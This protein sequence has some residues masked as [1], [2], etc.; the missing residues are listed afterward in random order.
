MALLSLSAQ[1]QRDKPDPSIKPGSFTVIGSVGFPKLS[2]V[3]REHEKSLKAMLLGGVD[4]QVTREFI[5]GFQYAN[6][7]SSH[8]LISVKSN[9]FAKNYIQQEASA[10]WHTLMLTAEIC[11]LNRGRW[12]LSGGIGLGM[13]YHSHYTHTIDSLGIS[14]EDNHKDREW[15]GRI[16]VINAKFRITNN[17]G[18]YAG[19]GLGY[20]GFATAGACY[21]F[22]GS[23]KAPKKKKYL[24]DTKLAIR[25]GSTTIIG[26]TGYPNVFRLNNRH[27][28][29]SV[30][31]I[32]LVGE[33]QLTKR[34]CVGLQYAY[35]Y[36]SSGLR[37]GYTF[38]GVGSTPVYAFDYSEEHTRHSLMGT[39]D[40]CYVNKGR[41]SLSSGFGF[42]WTVY[43]KTSKYFS[44]NQYHAS[45][46]SEPFNKSIP[47]FRF[48]L[49]N[50][51]AKIADGFG[52]YAGFGYGTDGVVAGGLFYNFSSKK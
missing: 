46:M 42:G 19:V 2:A 32:M 5:I 38:S 14:T 33:H 13:Q 6:N 7:H 24:D 51:K 50:V 29:K 1:A 45:Y 21:T 9:Y 22:G 25:P 20:D 41:F 17:L 10:T 43:T 36:S 48:R 28:G 4:Y 26:A 34:I 35:Q 18:A 40:Y 39:A 3:S 15:A 47:A 27:Q 12:N 31:P 37:K 52:V 16:R 8:D 11:Y 49:L 23:D 44:D 30:G